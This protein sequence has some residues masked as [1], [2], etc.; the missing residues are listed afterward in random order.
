MADISELHSWC[1]SLFI[2]ADLNQS[3]IL[4]WSFGDYTDLSVGSDGTFHALWTYSNN[5]Q[6][7]EWF[8]GA[9]SS[10]R[11]STNRTSPRRQASSELRLVTL[12]T[13]SGCAERAGPRWRP[14]T[15]M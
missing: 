7:V 2:L 4:E 10:Q 11:S 9:Q 12:A 13:W 15:V 14:P 8:Y 3:P 6:T 1:F 5:E